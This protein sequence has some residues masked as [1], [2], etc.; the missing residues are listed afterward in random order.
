M[1]RLPETDIAARLHVPTGSPSG[2]GDHAGSGNDEPRAPGRLGNQRHVRCPDLHH[3]DVGALGQAAAPAGPPGPGCRPGT[4]DGMARHAGSPVEEK[5]I[6]GSQRASS[7]P[8]AHH[9]L[10]SHT[11]DR[12]SSGLPC[13]NWPAVPFPAATTPPVH[14]CLSWSTARARKFEERCCD[15]MGREI[16]C[17]VRSGS[18]VGRLRRTSPSWSPSLRR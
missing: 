7:G 13:N 12:K 16:R 2:S 11:N 8:R 6:R 5:R 18:S 9:V 4:E 3:A 17:R 1:R 15:L 14:G 10:H